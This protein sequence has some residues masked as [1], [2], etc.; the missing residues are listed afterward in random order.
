[1]LTIGNILKEFNPRI[2]GFSTSSE[3][4]EH[5]GLNLS[6][7]DAVSKDF[8]AQA[9]ELIT[10]IR[11]NSDSSLKDEWKLVI[12]L[13]GQNDLCSLVCTHNGTLFKS[14]GNEQT[15]TKN[16]FASNIKKGLDRLMRGL[17]KTLVALV[18]PPGNVFSQYESNYEKRK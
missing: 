3:G 1:M 12:V 8:E 13:F 18:L 2:T 14:G 4:E 7:N 16:E 17:P 11:R 6:K 10:K 15:Q 9:E 5:D